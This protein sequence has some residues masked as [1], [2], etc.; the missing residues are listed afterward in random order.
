MEKHFCMAC[1]KE[2]E[3]DSKLVRYCPECQAKK[4]EE[5]KAKQ[6]A[7]AKERNARLNLTNISVYKDDKDFLAKT[8]KQRGITMA[9][10]LKSIIAG[11]TT[12][13]K[14]KTKKETKKA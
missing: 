14:P 12:E 3:T 1:G 7:Y 5:Q 2:F 11:M 9:E 4:K 6:K 10:L 8:A 13:E